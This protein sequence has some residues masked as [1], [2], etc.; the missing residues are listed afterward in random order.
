[1][2][3]NFICRQTNHTLTSTRS[4]K[5]KKRSHN[6]Q[7]LHIFID[8]NRVLIVPITLTYFYSNSYLSL[9]SKF[10]FNEFLQNATD[11]NLY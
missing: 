1:M 4:P 11:H 3:I 5:K 8:K 10:Y 9:K 7:N 6:T 2:Q